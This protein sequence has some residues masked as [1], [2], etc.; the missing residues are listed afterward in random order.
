MAKETIEKITG[1]NN[2]HC[3]TIG[4]VSTKAIRLNQKGAECD[5]MA[6]PRGSTLPLTQSEGVGNGGVTRDETLTHSTSCKR[7]QTKTDVGVLQGE[8]YQSPHRNRSHEWNKRCGGHN[9]TQGR[10]CSSPHRRAVSPH[11]EAVTLLQIT[12]LLVLHVTALLH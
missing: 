8:S 11:A 1:M 2:N 7:S 10:T 12:V 3:L 4:Q 9:A 6:W 5:N